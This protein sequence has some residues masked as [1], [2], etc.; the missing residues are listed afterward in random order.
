GGCRVGPLHAARSERSVSTRRGL[1][2]QRDTR[3]SQLGIAG[4]LC[5]VGN[6]TRTAQPGFLCVRGRWP[7]SSGEMRETIAVAGF[8]KNQFRTLRVVLDLIAYLSDI[9]A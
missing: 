1:C 3:V 4:A 8:G 7:N 5:G 6:L 9:D 2:R